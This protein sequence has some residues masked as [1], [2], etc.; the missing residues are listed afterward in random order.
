MNQQKVKREKVA[1]TSG[2]VKLPKPEKR[3]KLLTDVGKQRL[4]NVIDKLKAD[5]NGRL[6]FS[7]KAA[8]GHLG[9]RTHSE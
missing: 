4:R 1:D 8:L 2:D 6:D 5:A 7:D 9:F 3:L